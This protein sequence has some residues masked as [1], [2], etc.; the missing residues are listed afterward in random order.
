MDAKKKLM[1]AA[2]RELTLKE[3][4]KLAMDLGREQGFDHAKTIFMKNLNN[5]N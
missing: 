5:P 1:K 2:K 3:G 4:I